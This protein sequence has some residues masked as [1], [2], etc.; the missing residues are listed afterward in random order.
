M[1]AIGRRKGGMHRDGK[2]H[3]LRLFRPRWRRTRR[4]AWRSRSA[5]SPRCASSCS[6]CRPRP[7]AAPPPAAAAG[8][9]WSTA[10]CPLSTS[11]PSRRSVL[12]L[13]LSK[14]SFLCAR[15]LH[16]GRPKQDFDSRCVPCICN[17]HSV[18]LHECSLGTGTC[19]L[20]RMQRAAG[21]KHSDKKRLSRPDWHHH[22]MRVTRTV[23]LFYFSLMEDLCRAAR[24]R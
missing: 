17:A 12:P 16:A 21:A 7:P 20:R 10:P 2:E 14:N 23:P 8:A 22:F 5:R 15:N 11:A 18:T 1:A 13:S 4:S 6:R 9:S 24:R 3:V 19:S